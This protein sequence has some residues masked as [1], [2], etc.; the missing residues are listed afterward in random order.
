MTNFLLHSADMHTD[1]NKNEDAKDMANEG[2]RAG[3]FQEMGM[4]QEADSMA[5]PKQ[6]DGGRAAWLQVLGSFICMMNSL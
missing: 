6:Q 3:D 1:D 2:P 4:E 5:A